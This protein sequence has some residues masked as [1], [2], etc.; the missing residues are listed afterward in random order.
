MA[1][2]LNKKALIDKLTSLEVPDDTIVVVAS[3]IGFEDIYD[4]RTQ[5]LCF[6]SPSKEGV[7]QAIILD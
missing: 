1:T 2:P 3:G 6:S 4:I 7:F 5:E